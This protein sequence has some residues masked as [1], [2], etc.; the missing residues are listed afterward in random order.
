MESC[1]VNCK[2]C[3]VKP[4]SEWQDSKI[5]IVIACRRAINDYWTDQTV[6]IL[7]GIM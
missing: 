3:C 7:N 6:S 5:D 1:V 2:G 4:I